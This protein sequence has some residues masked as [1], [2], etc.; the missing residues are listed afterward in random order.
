MQFEGCWKFVA[1]SLLKFGVENIDEA[2]GKASEEEDDTN[3]CDWDSGFLVARF[4]M[5]IGR[6]E[7][8]ERRPFSCP[9]SHAFIA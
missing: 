5:L 3:N 9:T 2:A 8:E 4:S 1:G 7:A 6:D